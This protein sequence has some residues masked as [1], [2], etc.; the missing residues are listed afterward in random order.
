MRGAPLVAARASLVGWPR[1]HGSP[2]EQH[3]D[4]ALQRRQRR[5]GGCHVAGEVRF[6]TEGGGG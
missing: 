2:T 1:P 4:G 3:R 5:G 6:G